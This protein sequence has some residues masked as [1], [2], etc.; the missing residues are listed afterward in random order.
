MRSV[1]VGCGRLRLAVVGGSWLRLVVVGRG[2]LWSCAV[3]CGWLWSVVVGCSWAR[4]AVV[5][6]GLYGNCRTAFFASCWVGGCCATLK[7]LKSLR[8]LRTLSPHKK[9]K[10]SE[11][12]F[13]NLPIFSDSDRIQTCNRL[14]RSQVLYSVELRSR[15]A[16]A[17]VG[18]ISDTCK[19]FAKTNRPPPD[20]LWHLG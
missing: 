16:S 1:V 13:H 15:I 17:N 10:K 11:D 6:C 7:T 9:Q 8:T 4:L 19:Y 5:D 20:F 12:Y 18:Q 14:I 3:G 2:R